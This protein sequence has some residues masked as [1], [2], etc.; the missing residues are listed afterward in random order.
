MPPGSTINAAAYRDT[1]TRLRRAIQNLDNFMRG[2]AELVRFCK[3]I[4]LRSMLL[5][6]L[7]ELHFV[8]VLIML[9]LTAKFNTVMWN[10]TTCDAVENYR[11]DGGSV[12]F[13]VISHTLIISARIYGCSGNLKV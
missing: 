10:T 8:Y 7:T 13:T 12:N 3:G 6:S 2:S 5:K 11:V 9:Q 4:A 1:L